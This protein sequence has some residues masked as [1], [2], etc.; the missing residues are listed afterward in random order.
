[1][2]S[3]RP[4]LRA[5]R[6]LAGVV[7]PSISSRDGM[8]DFRPDFASW[9]RHHVGDKVYLPARIVAHPKESYLDC[10][11]EA[12]PNEWRPK[13][14]PPRRAKACSPTMVM[15]ISIIVVVAGP[16]TA[17][18]THPR[19]G[20]C[21][22]E[23]QQ[24]MYWAGCKQFAQKSNRKSIVSLGSAG[25]NETHSEMKM[26]RLR[27]EINILMRPPGWLQASFRAMRF[28]QI[29]PWRCESG[30]MLLFIVFYGLL[31]T[32]LLP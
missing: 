2:S 12:K 20:V 18:H 21:D 4:S 3:F 14:V 19:M 26:M 22:H 29:K 13:L 1:M 5:S 7:G 25:A 8:L 27:L 30:E 16:E 10:S 6:Q 15:I 28:Q 24:L 9:A 31:W 23:A 17:E 11:A 32:N